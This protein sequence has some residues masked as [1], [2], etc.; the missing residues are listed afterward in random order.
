LPLNGSIVDPNDVATRASAL[1]DDP[2]VAI[3]LLAQ[4]ATVVGSEID[5]RSLGRPCPP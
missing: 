5:F 4:E 1:M 2:R 3:H